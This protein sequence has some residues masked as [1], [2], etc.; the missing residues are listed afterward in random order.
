MTL[1]A[2]CGAH[3]LVAG[4]W[5]DGQALLLQEGR[6]AALCPISDVPASAVKIILDGGFLLPGFMDCQVN[7][8][9][10][11]L[12]NDQ[13][14]VEG[15]TAIAA[16]HRRYGTTGLLPTLISDDLSVVAE[17][18]LAVDTAI[19][20]GVP[21]VLGIHIE[22]PFL[23]ERKRGIH[24]AN[25]FRALDD[26]A[27]E[28]L[29]SLKH[30][31]TLVTLAPE[32]T[33]DATIATLVKRGVI[34]VAGHSLATYERMESAFAAGLCGVTHL[35]NAMTQLESRAPGVV[36]ATL[37]HPTCFAGLIADGYH[38]HAA[39]MRLALKAMGPERLML[40]TDAMP[41]VGAKDKNFKIGDTQITVENGMCCG[42]D[43]TLAGSDLDMASAL[44]NAMA[45]MKIDLATAATMASTTPAAFMGQSAL[46][47]SLCAGL[48][49]DIVHLDAAHIV[50]NTWIN[51]EREQVA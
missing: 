23:N 33:T 26:E 29:S 19:V 7:G 35:Y 30:G 44:R 46:R 43:G 41:S 20:A 40:V 28:L 39:S 5:R 10:G 42:P 22:G 49:A 45:M 38:V 12:L 21:G 14:T 25:K 8:G 13:P 4:Q 1:Q 17:A 6:I 37:D 3:M 2:L 50:Q 18:I 32:L 27:I 48:R 47:G 34:V 36:G 31:K 24:D 9:G 51:G 11:V 15:I 16:A